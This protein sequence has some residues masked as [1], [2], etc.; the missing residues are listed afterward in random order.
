MIAR[1]LPLLPHLLTGIIALSFFVVA[2]R[3]LSRAIVAF[4]LQSAALAG[5]A[6]LAS[7]QS[8]HPQHLWVLAGLTLGVKGVAVPLALRKA[9]DRLRITNQIEFIVKIPTS[10]MLAGLGTLG[11]FAL[12]RHLF[13]GE[14]LAVPGA[15][16]TGMA[17]L[18]LGLLVMLGRKKLITQIVGLLIMENGVILA[19]LGLTGGMP[20]IVE[21]GV[22]LDVLVAIQILALVAYRI[23]GKLSDAP[24]ETAG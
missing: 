18:V 24:K 8:A 14:A 6:L 16:G 12:A 10:V 1:L 3:R 15:L 13:A 19:T 22:A 2:S 20:L 5:V 23:S 7:V 4:A 17:T 11:A 9:A 21:I